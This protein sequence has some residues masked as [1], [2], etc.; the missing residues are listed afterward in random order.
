MAGAGELIGVNF[1]FV[2]YWLVD[3]SAMNWDFSS[4]ALFLE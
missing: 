1:S 4:W 2:D 3:D